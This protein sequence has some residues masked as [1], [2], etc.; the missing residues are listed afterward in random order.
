[1][2]PV[3]MIFTNSYGAKNVPAHIIFQHANKAKNLVTFVTWVN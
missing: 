1:M 2:S 3:K